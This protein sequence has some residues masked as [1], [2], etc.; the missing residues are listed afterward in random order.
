MAEG[1]CELLWLKII[2]DDLKINL[3]GLLK[4]YYDNKLV[5]DIAHNP[6]QHD[7][8]KHI[9]IDNTLHEGKI[10]RRFSMHVIY[11][12]QATCG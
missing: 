7:I 3:E 11:S 8:T 12:V 4:L 6:I 5:I 1:L 10:K 2:F 9:E